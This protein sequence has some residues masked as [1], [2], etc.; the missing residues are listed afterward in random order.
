M[1][2]LQQGSNGPDV[3]KLQQRLKDSGFDPNG[4]DGNFGPGT[5]AAL[6]AFQQS[7][8]LQ[9]DGIAGPQTLASL[10]LNGESEGQTSGSE[11]ATGGNDSSDVASASDLNLPGLAGKIPGSVIAQI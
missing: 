11:A 9:P 5:R 1:Q 4:V 6:I 3:S 7:K 2:I 8:G 10:Q